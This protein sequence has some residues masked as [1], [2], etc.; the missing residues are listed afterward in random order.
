MSEPAREIETTQPVSIDGLDQLFDTTLNSV[1]GVEQGTLFA[2]ANGDEH[3]TLFAIAN[4]DEHGT[5]FAIANGDEHGAHVT[6]CN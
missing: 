4:G 1:Q 2:I 5:L 6:M 3:G